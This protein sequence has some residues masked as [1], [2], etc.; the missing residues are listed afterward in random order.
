MEALE[1]MR[2]SLEGEEQHERICIGIVE[3]EPRDFFIGEKGWRSGSKGGVV[4]FIY[5][6]IDFNCLWNWIL[7]G[8]LRDNM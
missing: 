5:L 4:L 3:G 8:M 6:F 7:E 1:V 2:G